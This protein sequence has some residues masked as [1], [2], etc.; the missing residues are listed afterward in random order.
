MDGRGEELLFGA[1][2][3]VLALLLLLRIGRA[4]RTGTIP[5]YRTQLSR[6]QAGEARFWTLVVLNGAVF[7]LLFFIAADLLLGLGYRSGR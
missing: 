7:V 2:C 4:L 5:L 6:A 3:A 1:G